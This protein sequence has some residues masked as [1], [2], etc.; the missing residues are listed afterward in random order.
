MPVCYSTEQMTS[1]DP[2]MEDMIEES[3]LNAELEQREILGFHTFLL[4]FVPQP[5]LQSL[6]SHLQKPGFYQKPGFSVQG[7]RTATTYSGS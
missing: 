2:E 6:P 3:C 1:E 4:G 7:L 5:N